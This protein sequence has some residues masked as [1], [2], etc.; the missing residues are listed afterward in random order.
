MTLSCSPSGVCS[1]PSVSLNFG[2]ACQCLTL[3][4][5]LVGSCRVVSLRSKRPISKWYGGLLCL[6]LKTQW[7]AVTA[8]LWV[9]RKKISY[10][11]IRMNICGFFNSSLEWNECCPTHDVA[12]HPVQQLE[13]CQ[14]GV[15]AEVIRVWRDQFTADDPGLAPAW[16]HHKHC[17]KRQAE[18]N[19]LHFLQLNIEFKG[20]PVLFCRVSFSNIYSEYTVSAVST[21]ASSKKSFLRNS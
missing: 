20:P 19:V 21:L 4:H 11:C 18:I 17:R 12:Q 2:C 13:L 9:Q 1:W 5:S 7:A 3:L 8:V 6:N 15:V 14:A 16:C 10:S